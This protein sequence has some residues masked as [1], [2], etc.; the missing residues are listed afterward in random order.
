MKKVSPACSRPSLRS[1]IF[2]PFSAFTGEFNSQELASLNS[3]GGVA[4]WRD[5]DPVHLTYTAYGDIT[6][7]LVNVVK[8]SGGGDPEELQQSR[9][10]ESIVTRKGSDPAQKPVPGWLLGGNQCGARA[11]PPAAT[12][13]RAVEGKWRAGAAVPVAGGPPTR[14]SGTRQS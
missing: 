13:A 14:G 2:D 6:D 11:A 12:V 7:H 1:T 5:D 10:L 8:G 3:S 4:I 9:R